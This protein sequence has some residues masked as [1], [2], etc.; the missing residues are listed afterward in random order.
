MID[1]DALLRKCS[2]CERCIKGQRRR[3]MLQNSGFE[4][5][6]GHESKMLWK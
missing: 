2:G 1:T 5:F 4:G 6:I 3:W